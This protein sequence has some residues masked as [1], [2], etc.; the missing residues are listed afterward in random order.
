MLTP[1]VTSSTGRRPP[2]RRWF[3]TSALV[4][5]IGI[6]AAAMWATA[7]MLDVTNSPTS[8]TRLRTP[9]TTTIQLAQ[10]AHQVVYLEGPRGAPLQDP[11][12]TVNGP[13]GEALPLAAHRATVLYDTNGGGIGRAI[14]SFTARLSGPHQVTAAA[15]PGVTVAVGDDLAGHTL[16]ALAGPAIIAGASVLLAIILAAAPFATLSFPTRRTP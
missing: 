1:H 5:V 16:H 15:V 9:G 7:G 12:V 11:S 13:D 8:F 14:A 10:G 3:V 4:A 2:R 6:A